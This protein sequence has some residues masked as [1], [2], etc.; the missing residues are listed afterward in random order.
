MKENMFYGANSFIFQRAEELRKHMTPA[1]ESLWKYVH[2]NE[3]KLKFRRQ[4]PIAN[5]VVDF[6]CHQIKLVIEID[7]AIHDTE[8]VKRNDV[9][10]EKHLK[11][12]G[13]TILR[14][15]NDDIFNNK[16]AVIKKITQ[17]INELLNSPSGDG[18]KLYVIKVGGNVIDNDEALSSFLQSF[19]SI[20]GQKILVHGGGKLATELAE[21]LNIPQQMVD[22]RRITDAET[23]KVVTMVYAGYINKTIVAKL[24]SYN[25]NAIG[26]SGADGNIVLTHKRVHPNID[27]GFVGDIDI[28]NTSLLE[29]C[30]DINYSIVIAPIT[31]DHDGQLLNT[32]ADTIVQEIAKALTKLYDVNLIY[33]FEKKG[34]LMDAND[35][36]T[37]ISSIDSEHYQQLKS[38][39]KI[40]AGMIP[41]LD[42]A[43]EALNNRV[44]KVIIGKAEDLEQLVIGKSGTTIVNE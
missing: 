36:S 3:W 23:L 39:Q 17:T 30:L 32:N 33:C 9:E 41:K 14:F 22:G 13:L 10:R 6:Y 34:V 26:L 5:W 25:C 16:D 42:N 7:G 43:F 1:E 44:K 2:I 19:A 15:K 24:Q 11:D 37:V 21:R 40:F 8:E 29:A 31:A 20:Q 28:V 35:E 18:G 38:E 4:H 27:Y 12:F